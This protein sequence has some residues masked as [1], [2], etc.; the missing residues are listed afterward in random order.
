MASPEPLQTLLPPD[1]PDAV[2][3]LD[4]GIDAE[5]LAG[6]GRVVVL[7]GYV[8]MLL[9]RLLGQFC[10]ADASAMMAVAA[11]LSPDGLTV[12]IAR[13]ARQKL[14]GND[15]DRVLA[16]LTDVDMLRRE[17]DMLV[18]GRWD[19]GP[20]PGTAAIFTPHPV[21]REVMQVV[22]IGARDLAL[23]EDH[24]REVVQ[25]LTVLCVDLGVAFD[26]TSAP[27]R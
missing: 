19:R 6:L 10:G 22:G 27:A 21:R 18:R 7:W 13:L 15:L 24:G 5:L 25:A 20:A 4:L 2:E 1:A 14:A 26:G 12:S 17:R 3:A 23:I 16:C 8:E 11:E 9:A